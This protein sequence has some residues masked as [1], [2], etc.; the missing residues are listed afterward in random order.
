MRPTT[1]QLLLAVQRAGRLLGVDQA[2]YCFE[3]RFKL[4]LLGD[5]SLVISPD[6]A[7]RLR[8]E[9]CA[10]ERV[11]ATM[12][13][14]ATDRERFAELVVGAAAEAALLAV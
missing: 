1:R 12:W 11:R 10:C 6:D 7:G 8:L 13:C 4:D 2:T 14:L 5:W 3:G 9:A